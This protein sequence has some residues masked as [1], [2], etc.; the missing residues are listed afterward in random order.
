MEDVTEILRKLIMSFA[1]GAIMLLGVMII[2]KML[3]PI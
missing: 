1:F 2:L 3:R